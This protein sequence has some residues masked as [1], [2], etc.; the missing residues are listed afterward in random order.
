MGVFGKQD[1]G[2]EEAFDGQ[3]QAALEAALGPMES[4]VLHAMIPFAL[5]GTLDLYPFRRHIP[6]TLYVTQ[7][8]FTADKRSRP[9]KSRHGWYELAA[10]FRDM[11]APIGK[12]PASQAE[13]EA[14]F[15]PDGEMRGP[16]KPQ[17]SALQAGALLNPMAMYAGMAV[18]N[19][20]ETAEFPGD[21]GEPNVCVLLDRL[22]C[23]PLSVGGTPFFIMLVIQI[24][25]AELGLARGQ[26][27]AVL[28]T[29]LK[30]MGYYP[31]SDMDRPPVA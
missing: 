16:G 24:H 4:Y 14:S 5:G 29:R 10:A 9:K 7:E 28:I 1:A 11:S 12:V 21:E 18:L 31:Y 3:K 20:G 8:L 17:E 30:E 25:P 26:G 6:G 23:A 13:M 15:G 22:E 27:S 19:P 2:N